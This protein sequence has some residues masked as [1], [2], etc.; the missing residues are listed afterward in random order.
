[1]TASDNIFYSSDSHDE[2]HIAAGQQ[3]TRART[4]PPRGLYLMTRAPAPLL[5]GGRRGGHICRLNPRRRLVDPEVP[6]LVVV[7]GE[8]GGAPAPSRIWPWP[9]RGGMAAVAARQGSWMVVAASHGA[10]LGRVAEQERRKREK[11]S[12]A[13]M[14]GENRGSPKLG[15]L[16]QNLEASIQW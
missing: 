12:G 7:H 3:E 10:G 9:R 11:R 14:S 16:D 6:L 13:H 5:S 1:M 8:G 15:A 2:Q 4:A